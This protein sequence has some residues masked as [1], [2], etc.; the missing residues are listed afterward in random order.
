M[1]V[2]LTEYINE[3]VDVG[4]TKKVDRAGSVVY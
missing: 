2:D 3:K 1:T 4:V